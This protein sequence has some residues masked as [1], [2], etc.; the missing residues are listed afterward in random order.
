MDCHRF[1]LQ[2]K[3]ALMLETESGRDPGTLPRDCGASMLM[4]S[5]GFVHP[6][7]GFRARSLESLASEIRDYRVT[8]PVA[9]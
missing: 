8:P 5:L 9:S 6:L 4:I 2:L 7:P 3:I 1:Q